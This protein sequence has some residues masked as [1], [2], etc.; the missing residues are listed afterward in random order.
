MDT[1]P[2]KSAVDTAILAEFWQ[3][4]LKRGVLTEAEARA[5]IPVVLVTPADMETPGYLASLI[6]PMQRMVDFELEF[7]DGHDQG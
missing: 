3:E 5:L 6:G 1:D 7:F 4:A 2:L